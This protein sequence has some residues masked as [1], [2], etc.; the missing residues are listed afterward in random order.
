VQISC[1]RSE[2][3]LSAKFGDIAYGV[4]KADTGPSGDYSR[5][6]HPFA[7]NPSRLQPL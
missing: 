7:T 1:Y 4:V 6:D 5:N 2:C 3:P